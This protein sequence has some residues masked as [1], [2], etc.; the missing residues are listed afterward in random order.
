MISLPSVFLKSQDIVNFAKEMADVCQPN[1]IHWF[2]GSQEEYN[3]LCNLLV[4][5]GTFK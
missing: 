1:D 4:L 2:D 3:A 5:N